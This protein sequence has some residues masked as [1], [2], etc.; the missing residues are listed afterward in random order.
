[1]VKVQKRSARLFILWNQQWFSVIRS[2]FQS[3]GNHAYTS[4]SIVR[5]VSRPATPQAYSEYS[6]KRRSSFAFCMPRDVRIDLMAKYETH[7]VRNRE[8]PNSTWFLGACNWWLH[9]YHLPESPVNVETHYALPA[10]WRHEAKVNDVAC[11][12]VGCGWRDGGWAVW[13]FW[14]VD[15]VRCDRCVRFSSSQCQWKCETTFI[16]WCR[17]N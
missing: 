5:A 11:G 2:G 10:E 9:V 4:N 8:A 17:V 15:G 1:M 16:K 14:L 6:R 12:F 13:L 3:L 7:K